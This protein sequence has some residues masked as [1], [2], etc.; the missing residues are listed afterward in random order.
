[1][2][3]LRIRIVLS[4][5]KKGIKMAA[6]SLTT[7]NYRPVSGSIVTGTAGE[8]I[9]KNKW[10]YLNAGDNKLY[11]ASNA[12]AA[13]AN[14]VGYT[15]EAAAADEDAVTYLSNGGKFKYTSA[16]FTAN[17][18]YELDA[19]GDMQLANENTSG[20]YGALVGFATSTTEFTID[21]VSTGVATA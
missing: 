15:T 1:M 8:A 19:S 20:E 7:A 3:W 12:A 2:V 4:G 21:I 5:N 11:L 14:P 16:T 9:G 18:F 10:V 17:K 6:I 13:T